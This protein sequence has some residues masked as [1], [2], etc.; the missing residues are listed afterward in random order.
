MIFLYKP[1][2]PSL[3][4][5]L[6]ADIPVSV[7]LFETFPPAQQTIGREPENPQWDFLVINR[8]ELIFFVFRMCIE[9]FQ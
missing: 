9:N 5:K 8:Y 2:L 7:S 6:V 1:C 3:R 4:S